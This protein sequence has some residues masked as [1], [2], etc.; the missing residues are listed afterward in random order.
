MR[1]DSVLMK[2]IFSVK[3]PMESD[4][5]F[6]ILLE[7]ASACVRSPCAALRAVTRSLAVNSLKSEY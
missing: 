5:V 2:C 4:F 3:L 6:S 1:P 7:A